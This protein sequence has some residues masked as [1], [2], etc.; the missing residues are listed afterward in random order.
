MLTYVAVAV[1]GAAGAMTRY[2]LARVIDHRLGGAF[3][4]GT[5]SVNLLGSLAIGILWALLDKQAD[6][7]VELKQL[8]TVGF[9][10]AF[11]TFSTFSLD[12]MQ[13]LQDAAYGKAM[14]NVLMNVVLCI[15][16]AWLGTQI[17]RWR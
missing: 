10:G 1:G 14:V 3:P 5:L 6:V 11:T 2:G 17:T 8:L 15:A 9:L 16:A 4:Y 12:T 7:P 13:L